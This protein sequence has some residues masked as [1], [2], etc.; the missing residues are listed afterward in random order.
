[1]KSFMQVGV[2][3][4]NTL[5]KVGELT[6]VKPPYIGLWCFPLWICYDINNDINF[7]TPHEIHGYIA[8]IYLVQIDFNSNVVDSFGKQFS[9]RPKIR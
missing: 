1:M 2:L 8:Y 3:K 9:R 5:T 6:K 7:T 4:Q